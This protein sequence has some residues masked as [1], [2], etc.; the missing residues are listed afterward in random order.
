VRRSHFGCMACIRFSANLSQPLSGLL[1]ERV[2]TV[3][4][5]PT[6]FGLVLVERACQPVNT[7]VDRVGETSGNAVQTVRGAGSHGNGAGTNLVLDAPVGMLNVARVDLGEVDGD[8]W[9]V[10][11][12]A[13]TNACGAGHFVQR[14][15]LEATCR[16]ERGLVSAL[17]GQLWSGV[18]HDGLPRH[19]VM[20]QLGGCPAAKLCFTRKQ[21]TSVLILALIASEELTI[22]RCVPELLSSRGMRT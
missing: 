18:T 14:Q 13:D 15:M 2:H 4:H 16:N 8:V 3:R 9:G 5:E 21:P 20:V 1:A 12:R 11:E 22:S 19:Y 7:V 6:P 17:R 10:V